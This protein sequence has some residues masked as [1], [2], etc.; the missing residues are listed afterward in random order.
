MT[1]NKPPFIGASTISLVHCPHCSEYPKFDVNIPRG[2]LT[3]ITI[4]M[5]KKIFV[6]R[7][8]VFVPIKLEILPVHYKSSKEDYKTNQSTFY[9]PKSIASILKMNSLNLQGRIKS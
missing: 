8:E 5:C 6:E 3:L 9:G 4:K 1:V 7:I 2:C